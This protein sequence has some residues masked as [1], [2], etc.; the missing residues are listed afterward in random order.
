M[1][2]LES[3]KQKLMIKPT[4][5]ER[6]KVAV[7]IKGEKNSK[8]RIREEKQESLIEIEIG[9]EKAE[10]D[11]KIIDIDFGEEEKKEPETRPLIQIIDEREKGFDRE[12]LLKKLA[13]NKKL[14]V[15]SKP[16]IQIQQEEEKIDIEPTPPK[17]A[18]KVEK[19]RKLIIEPEEGEDEGKKAEDEGKKEAK[20]PLIIEEEEEII[21]PPKSKERKTK[22]VEKGVAIVGPEILLEIGD[23]PIQRRMPHK[24]PP[25][26]IRVSSYYMNNREI[27]VNF[28]NSLFEPYR[29]EIQDNEENISCDTIGKTSTEFSLLTHQKIVRDYMNLYTPYRGLLLY[30]GLGSGKTCTSIAIAEGM[31]NSKRIIIMTPASLRRNYMEELKKCGD[32]IYKKNQYWE[33]ISTDI[34]PDAANTLSQLMNLPID[35]IRRNR[36]AWLINISKPSNYDTLSSN[37]KKTLDLQLDEMIKQKYT[38]INYNGLRLKRLEELTNGFTKN[39]FDDAVVVIDEAHNLISRIVNKIKLEKGIDKIERKETEG[40]PRFLSTKLYEYLLSAKN[41]KII[42]LS[43]TPV[44]NY[45]NEFGILF[46]ILR[47]YIK[48]WYI[49]LDVKTTKKVDKTFLSDLLLGEK[50]LDYLDYSPSSKILT[51][52]RNPF[53]FKNKIKKES[54]YQGVSNVKKDENGSEIF[55][56][57]FISDDDFERRIIN[58]LKRNDIDVVASGIKIHNKK[59]LPDTFEH[60]EGQYI[61]NVTKKLINVDSLKR[62]IIGLSSY[63]RSAQEN[64]LPRFN[65]LLGV[66]YH[67]V[68]IPMSDFQFKIY[69][70]AR[71]EERKLEKKPMMKKIPTI[72]DLYEPSSTYRIFSRLFCNFTMPERPKPIKAEKAKKD[73]DGIENDYETRQLEQQLEPY[74]TTLGLNV[75]ATPSEI[76]TAYRQLALK[77]HPDKNK[78]EDAAVKFRSIKDAYSTLMDKSQ[79]IELLLKAAKKYQEKQDVNQEQE[80]EVEGDE[81]LD[82]IGGTEYKERL[83]GAIRFLVENANDYLTPEALQTYSP[84]FLHILENIKDP[85]YLGLHLVYSQFRT[86]EGI[87]LFSAVLDKNGFTR[88]KIKK[89]NTGNWE[90]D[91]AEENLGKPT[92]A[93][94]TGTETAEEKEIIRNIYNGDWEYIPTNIAN[95]LK[96]IAN[97]NNMG[98]IIKVLMIT[99]S[100]S[101]GINLRNTRYVHIMEPYWHP[102]R[103]EQVIGRARRICSHKSLPPALQTVEVFV[104]LMVLSEAQIKSDDA[105]ELKR[106]DL[107]KATPKVPFTSDQY[108]YEISEIKANLTKQLTDAIKESSFDCYVYSNGNCM[109]FGDPTNSKFSYVPDY[110]EQQSDITVKSNK[111]K[112]E[113]IGKPITLNGVEYVYRRISPKVL[114]IYDK[115][116]YMQALET[117]GIMPVQIGSLEVNERGEQVFKQLVS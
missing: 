23:T 3:I 44:I 54:G 42:L 110:S 41:S 20:K 55:D 36:G 78:E 18:K 27:F 46:N 19:M 86:A 14:K 60:F 113:W 91:I 103:L 82:E 98:E 88:F 33:W 63:F 52:T 48:T 87:G 53:G 15:V 61:D 6:Q 43:G 76:K 5:E 2:P 35:Y 45:P 94:Y 25:V 81:I 16:A 9:E 22:K 107:S 115:A 47:G 1:N 100:G 58:I 97:N 39:L 111:Q 95:E 99:S 114:N 26:N 69:E 106:H 65:K 83:E 85:E 34:N 8:K 74:Y 31:K 102:V 24:M 79:D 117:P 49:P 92:Y 38:F 84:K 7:A 68:R 30:H 75:G 112:I 93:L 32:L 90:I 28:I 64:L 104:Y 37:D 12:A 77:Y 72:E 21:I 96:K 17:K 80:G 29:R 116:S 67:V 57:D 11:S 13:E 4:V 105:I 109:N 70:S 56:N 89:N 101:E 62:R 71:K 51:I 50:S 66:D 40:T 73:G 59:A 10:P 108:L